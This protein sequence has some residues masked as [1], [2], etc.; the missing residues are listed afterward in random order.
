[1]H[2]HTMY[3]PALCSRTGQDSDT[4]CLSE[5]FVQPLCVNLGGRVHRPV[6]ERG[7]HHTELQEARQRVTEC[8][9]SIPRL[10]QGD[11]AKLVLFSVR[12]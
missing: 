3:G 2:A 12:S 4:D 10:A 9:C 5:H 7:P 1:M 8:H 11:R 6:W